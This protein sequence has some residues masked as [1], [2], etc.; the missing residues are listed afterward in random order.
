MKRFAG[1][2]GINRQPK[3]RIG[4]DA[5]GSSWAWLVA[6]VLVV[7]LLIHLA[8]FLLCGVNAKRQAPVTR[9]AQAYGAFAVAG[10]RVR[11]SSR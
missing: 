11:L 5:A 8:D 10:Q 2:L 7:V 6:P 1:G 3:A 4:Q 9:Y